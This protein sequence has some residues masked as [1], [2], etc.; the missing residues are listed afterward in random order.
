[1]AIGSVGQ[2]WRGENAP[3]KGGGGPTKLGMLFIE[4]PVLFHCRFYSDLSRR[5]RCLRA[6]PIARAMPRP[7]L[8]PSAQL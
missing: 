1:M 6:I 4:M 8:W 3:A 7:R 5:P 2:V